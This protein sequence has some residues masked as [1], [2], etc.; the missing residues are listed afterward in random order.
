MYK[1]KSGL[2]KLKNS[3]VL[4]FGALLA[5]AGLLSG[6]SSANDNGKQV[7]SEENQAEKNADEIDEDAIRI[8]V[9]VD[10]GTEYIDEKEVS[11]E[12]GDK[13]LDVMKENFYI[14][15]DPDEKNITSIDGVS[16]EEDEEKS[17]VFFINDEI[18]SGDAKEIE[19]TPGDKITWDLQA[20]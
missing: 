1:R 12:K 4:R 7:S 9:S 14:E 19:L 5:L 6:C 3:W 10:D 15:T 13:L 20:E 8:T 11:V 18:A 2:S 16:S 17:W